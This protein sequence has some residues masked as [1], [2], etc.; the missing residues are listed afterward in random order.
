MVVACRNGHDN[1]VPDTPQPNAT[2][3]CGRPDC[4][5]PIDIVW[6]PSTVRAATAQADT[7]AKPY[8]ALAAPDSTTSKGPA[9]ACIIL[10]LLAVGGTWPYGF[11]ILLRFVVCGAVAYLTLAAHSLN[12]RVWVWV[13]GGI[14]LLFNPIVRIPMPRPN[15]QVV[16]FV[17]A[18]VF[19][20]S[21]VGIRQATEPRG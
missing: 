3:Q 12:K 16:D 10:L 17:T 7:E 4:K 18:L 19:A 8:A 1:R 9:I 20:A 15:W 21:L 6:A 13:M 14:A 5:A 11:Y 2:Y